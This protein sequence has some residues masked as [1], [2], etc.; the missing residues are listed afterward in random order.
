MNPCFWP[1]LLPTQKVGIVWKDFV[2]RFMCVDESADL[3]IY[4]AVLSGA[5]RTPEYSPLDDVHRDQVFI[6]VI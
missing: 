3:N 4:T 2:A 6:W 1:S 5:V